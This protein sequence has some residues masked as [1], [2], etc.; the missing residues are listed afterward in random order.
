MREIKEFAIHCSAT[1]PSQDIGADEI[2]K[3]HL[4][5]GWSDIGYHFVINRKG[6][7]Q[8][9]RPVDKPGAHV[10]GHNADS[11]GICLVGGINEQGKA[12]A[13]FTFSQYSALH[14]LVS[15]LLVSY[16]EVTIL[17]HRDFPGVQ[18]ACPCFDVQSFFS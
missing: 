8:T 1:R 18:K 14:N 4:E 6:V 13:N 7:I 17:G 9:G 10:K 3:W 5:K 11:I 12:D 2:R 16:P 15:N